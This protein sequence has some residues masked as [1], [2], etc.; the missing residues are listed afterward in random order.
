MTHSTSKTELSAPLLQYWPRRYT[1]VALCFLAAFLCYI[2]RVNIS[3]AAIA[4]QERFGWSTATKGLV[5]SSFFAGYLVFQIAGGWLANRWGGRRVLGFAVLWWSICTV[6]TPS[7]ALISLPVLI[8]ARIAMGLGE[9]VMFP[10][11]YSLF[12]RWV[13]KL[14]R[15]RAVALVLSGVPLG[16]LFALTTTGWLLTRYGWPSTFYLFGAL[17]FI[18]ALFWF[19]L[20]TDDPAGDTRLS[21]TERSLLREH[22]VDSSQRVAV[23]WRRLLANRAVWALIVNHFCSNW[24]LYMLLAWLPSYF[25]DVQRLGIVNAGL[26]SAAPWL[27]MFLMSNAGGWFADRLISRGIDLTWVRKFMQVTGLLGSAAFLWCAQSAATPG[28]ALILM[29]GA[30]GA[31]ALTWSGFGPNH[32]DIAPRHADVLMGITNTAGTIPGV[33]GVA[34]TG[35]MVQTSGTYASAFMLAAAINVVGALVWLTAGTARRV[36]Y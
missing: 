13:P 2:D 23:P 21:S 30:M 10:S 25:R 5:L 28:V 14:E 27:T 36:V 24:T 20:L 31:L 11:A 32:M 35:W 7:A 8:G 16:T 4:M 9:G 1:V 19:A 17:G 34:L 29:C 26:F 15:S 18:W 22:C 33:V 3:V 6:L 12:G